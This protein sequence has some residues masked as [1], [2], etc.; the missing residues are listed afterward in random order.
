MVEGVR[1]EHSHRLIA[2]LVL[3]LM[4]ALTGRIA[5]RSGPGLV[6][7]LAFLGMGAVVAQALL[8]GLTVL[9]QLPPAVSVAHAVLAQ[10]FFST[11]V[12][13]AAATGPG[14]SLPLTGA[15]VLRRAG[16]AAAGALGIQILLGAVMRHLG[17]GHEFPYWPLAGGKIVPAFYGDPGRMA[18]FAH[19]S[20]AWL[21]GALVLWAA[22]RSWHGSRDHGLV[23][24]WG[25][26]LPLLLA[27]QFTLGAQA[28]WLDL[29]PLVTALHVPVGGLLLAGGV[30]LAVRSGLERVLH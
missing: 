7:N 19:R 8:G 21:T 15:R 9:L 26:A 22:H 14:W 1:F 11:I 5:R 3:I 20:W 27:L 6:R 4:A 30:L 13:L 25:L 18:N 23:R 17:A 10:G 12:T 29:P 16:H 2:G 24:R 28:V